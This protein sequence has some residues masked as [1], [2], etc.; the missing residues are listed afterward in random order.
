MGFFQNKRFYH[1]YKIQLEEER[2]YSKVTNPDFLTYIMDFWKSEGIISLFPLLTFMDQSCQQ[3]NQRLFQHL[4]ILQVRFSTHNENKNHATAQEYHKDL[5]SNN[6][7][8]CRAKQFS[9]DAASKDLPHLNLILTIEKES[10][11]R[12]FGHFYRQAVTEVH[13]QKRRADYTRSET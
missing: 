12:Y 8:L 5:S 1:R 10:K 11:P 3:E 2:R 6:R 4:T 7:S 9:Q 13:V